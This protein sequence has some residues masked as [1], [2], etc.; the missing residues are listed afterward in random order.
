MEWWRG[1]D[2]EKKWEVPDVCS[3][4][5]DYKVERDEV[6]MLMR[7]HKCDDKKQYGA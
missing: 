5:H 7:E 6:V 4:K 1:W 2:G 3:S